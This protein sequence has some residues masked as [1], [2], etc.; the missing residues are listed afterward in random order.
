MTDFLNKR[1]R[2][3]LIVGSGG[4]LP[5]EHFYFLLPKVPF[6]GPLSHSDRIKT[7]TFGL[8]GV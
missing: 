8:A 2:S 5:R 1:R 4:M 7:L 6:P 3:K